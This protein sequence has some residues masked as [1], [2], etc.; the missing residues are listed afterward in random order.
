[1]LVDEADNPD[2]VATAM[3][4]VTTG[5][6]S[7]RAMTSPQPSDTDFPVKKRTASNANHQKQP[8]FFSTKKKRVVPERWAKPSKN[9]RDTY[10]G[11]LETV[12]VL[13]C[14]VCFKQDDLE[15]SDMVE[16][17]QCSTW[18]HKCCV[19]ASNDYFICNSCTC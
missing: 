7:L 17:I 19:D 4:H 14:G 12:E 9:E 18:V 6:H 5:I 8:S 2:G 16:W 10:Y 3:R 13:H 1:M 15:S 11:M